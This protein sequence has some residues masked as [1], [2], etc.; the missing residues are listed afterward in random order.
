LTQQVLTYVKEASVA[1]N[2]RIMIWNLGQIA[3][4]CRIIGEVTINRIIEKPS[5]I[6][7]YAPAQ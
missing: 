6:C 1:A 5:E 7:Q 3:K 2:H 4:Y